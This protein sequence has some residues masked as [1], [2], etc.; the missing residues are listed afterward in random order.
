MARYEAAG[1]AADH[2]AE[3]RQQLLES[4]RTWAV[5]D[6]FKDFSRGRLTDEEMRAGLREYGREVLT[7]GPDPTFYTD[8]RIESEIARHK[9]IY[10]M[11]APQYD[12]TDARITDTNPTLIQETPVN[13][14]DDID[15]FLDEHAEK[16]RRMNEDAEAFANETGKARFAALLR[17]R[18][19]A[20]RLA[21]KV[22]VPTWAAG[23]ANSVRSIF[24]Q[25]IGWA[26]AAVLVVFSRRGRA[27]I[28][29]VTTPVRWVGRKM[30]D[31]LRKTERGTRVADKLHDAG[32]KVD[33]AQRTFFSPEMDRAVRI[34]VA[35]SILEK[36]LKNNPKARPFLLAG[37]IAAH[38]L[39]M[40]SVQGRIGRAWSKAKATR[41][42]VVTVEETPA[43]EAP[44]APKASRK[45][46]RQAAKGDAAA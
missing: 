2:L 44:A 35:F 38:I 41:V 6:L 29:L 10:G 39:S 45:E 33:S 23:P 24:S 31:L 15:T 43:A 42:K 16:V 20:R 7:A 46:R 11:T 17:L 5:T 1:M 4:R 22:N 36:V 21:E 14:T 18:R 27:A 34:T 28:R 32:Q 3:A 9:E 12:I 25:Y 30:A 8:A 40:E 13:K 37:K 26:N 19:S